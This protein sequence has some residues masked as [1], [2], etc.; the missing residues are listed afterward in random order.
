MPAS[1]YRSVDP[2][3]V[4]DANGLFRLASGSPAVDASVGYLL[5]CDA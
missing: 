5:L 2:K 3:L 4:K 1:G